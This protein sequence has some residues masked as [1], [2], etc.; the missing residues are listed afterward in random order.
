MQLEQ[1]DRQEQRRAKA[2]WHAAKHKAKA[3]PLA[4][5]TPLYKPKGEKR[6]WRW[7]G[8]ALESK[9]IYPGVRYFSEEIRAAGFKLPKIGGKTE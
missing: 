1:L 2:A 4:P 9:K 8:E 5:A 3:K 7:D 6:L